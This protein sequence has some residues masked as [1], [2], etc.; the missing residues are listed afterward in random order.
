VTFAVRPEGL[1]VVTRAADERTETDGTAD[2]NRIH[3]RVERSEFLGETTRVW[4]DWRGREL[5]VRTTDPLDGSVTL[6]FD[7]ADARIVDVE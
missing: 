2:E 5:T 1:R 7:S 6:A 3:A 4:L